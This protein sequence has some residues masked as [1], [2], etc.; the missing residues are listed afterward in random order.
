MHIQKAFLQMRM[1][2]QWAN[3]LRERVSIIIKVGGDKKPPASFSNQKQRG[4][5]SAAP[6]PTTTRFNIAMGNSLELGWGYCT[7]C[8]QYPQVPAFTRN[9]R[10]GKQA[11]PQTIP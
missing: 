1:N 4:G 6:I 2:I 3:N 9:F 8:R 11:S 10:V 5:K 7:A